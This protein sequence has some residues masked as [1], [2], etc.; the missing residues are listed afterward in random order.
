MYL[1]YYIFCAYLSKRGICA[2]SLTKSRVIIYQLFYLFFRGS[3]SCGK[4]YIFL[5]ECS[6]S[7]FVLTYMHHPPYQHS[8]HPFYH[9]LSTY[10]PQPLLSCHSVTTYISLMLR[11]AVL[12]GSHCYCA[13]FNSVL[14]HLSS[15]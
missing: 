4:Y 2:Y 14:Y 13:E 3:T 11:V 6:F 1:F 7:P 10:L 8:K 9:T 12:A 5:C 15:L